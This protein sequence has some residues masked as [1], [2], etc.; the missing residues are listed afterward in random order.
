MR[1]SQDRFTLW[2]IE[3]FLATVEEASISAAARRLGT[4]P[5][6]VSQQ[7]TNLEGAIGVTLLNRSHRPVLPT[8]AGET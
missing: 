4:S 3:V 5:A 2:G 6:T 7:L 1:A 8:P